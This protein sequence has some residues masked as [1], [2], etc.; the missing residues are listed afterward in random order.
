MRLQI[1]DLKVSIEGKKIL[2]GID[3]ELNTGE[4]HH[5][6]PSAAISTD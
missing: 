4:V 5:F 3:L 6:A 1:K 2:K